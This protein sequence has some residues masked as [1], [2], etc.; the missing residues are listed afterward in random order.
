MIVYFMLGQDV[1][2]LPKLIVVS[3]IQKYI[4]PQLVPCIDRLNH[5]FGLS[6]KHLA[7]VS[8]Y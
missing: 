6:P 1:E 8:F 7:F 5:V 3:A 4:F 2:C